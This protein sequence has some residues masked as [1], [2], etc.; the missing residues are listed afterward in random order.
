MKKPLDQIIDSL[1]EKL[2]QLMV[3]YS[4]LEQDY[5]NCQEVLAQE[6][7]HTKS[8]ESRSIELMHQNKLLKNTNA[9]LGSDEY[10]KE[11]KLKINA[12]VKEID[13]CIAQLS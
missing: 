10:K 12:L 9:L 4:Q 11:T 3:N 2:N 8:L 7:L 13:Q 1:E 6:R 5:I